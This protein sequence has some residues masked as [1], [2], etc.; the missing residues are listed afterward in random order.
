MDGKE[1]PLSLEA[2]R[3]PGFLYR[4]EGLLNAR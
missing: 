1:L 2:R 4:L 3:K